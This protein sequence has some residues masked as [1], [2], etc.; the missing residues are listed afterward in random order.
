M[1]NR[2]EESKRLIF[3]L[4]VARLL[5][6]RKFRYLPGADPEKFLLYQLSDTGQ[7]HT[8]ILFR[9]LQSRLLTTLKS[10]RDEL[11]EGT[12]DLVEACILD[13][14]QAGYDILLGKNIWKSPKR[15]EPRGIASPFIQV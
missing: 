5:L 11:L 3:A 7:R 1:E 2:E 6:L 9:S 10:I 12:S 8:S 15:Q 4:I 13:E 14:V